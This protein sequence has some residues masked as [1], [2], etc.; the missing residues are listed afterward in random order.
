MKGKRLAIH[1][2]L[3]RFKIISNQSALESLALIPLQGLLKTLF[4][5]SVVP[6]INTLRS[7]RA[8][9]AHLM[10]MSFSCK[11]TPSVVCRFLFQTGSTSSRRW[12]SITMVT[13]S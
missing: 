3:R 6:L 10:L 13:S 2:D 11:I 8:V 5:V 4:Q 12:W 9:C 1:L 7:V